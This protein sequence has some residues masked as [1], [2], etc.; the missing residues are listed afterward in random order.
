MEQQI[1]L[2]RYIQAHQSPP[3][4]LK[5]FI[6]AYKEISNG[7][8]ES[9]WMWYIFPQIRGLGRSSTSQYYAIQSLDEAKAFLA[10]SYL[11]NN[12]KSICEALLK[13]EATNVTEIFGK[14]DDKKLKSSMTLFSCAADC[15]HVFDKVL[16]KFFNG[17]P[18]YRTLKIL[19]IQQ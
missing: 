8:K 2:S 13:L 19:E 11:G 18:D 12:L 10:D 9:H 5:D 16:G 15:D 3:P 14:P 4:P 1:D 7:K 6:T 17:E